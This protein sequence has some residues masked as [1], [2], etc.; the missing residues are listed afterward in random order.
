M[1]KS[2]Y[3]S[4][5]FGIEES[6]KEICDINTKFLNTRLGE[7]LK[8]Y[9][10]NINNLIAEKYN[11]MWNAKLYIPEKTKDESIK[12]TIKLFRII[13]CNAKQKDVIEYFKRN[14]ISIKESIYGK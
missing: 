6:P 8:K 3:V 5:I 11:D 14:R 9:K 2:E 10:I 1:G 13:H 12:T 7:A 4:I